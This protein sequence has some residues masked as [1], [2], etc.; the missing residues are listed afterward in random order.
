MAIILHDG[1]EGSDYNSYASLEA[2]DA[3]QRARKN[4]AWSEDYEDDEREAA[5]IR[6]TDYLDTAYDLPK[7]TGEVHPL[8]V[9]ATVVLAVY[10]LKHDFFAKQER[11]V[12]E[13]EEELSGVTKERVKYDTNAPNDPYPMITRMLA[14]ITGQSGGRS[15]TVGKIIR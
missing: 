2:A 9:R 11:A 7:P 1:S 14:P 3:Y 15:A 12:L 13:T 10:A 8:I 4:A 5:L 6:A